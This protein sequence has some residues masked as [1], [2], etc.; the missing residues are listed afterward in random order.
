M[1]AGLGGLQAPSFIEKKKNQWCQS[2]SQ[3]H[4]YHYR[5][6]QNLAANFRIPGFSVY[7][8]LPHTILKRPLIPK[9]KT[10]VL[11]TQTIALDRAYFFPATS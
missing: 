8:R 6:F 4:I 11:S 2:E 1:I 9:E 5:V 3:T 7:K 10:R